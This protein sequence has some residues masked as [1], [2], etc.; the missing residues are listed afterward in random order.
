[1]REDSVVYR[2]Q[3]LERMNDSSSRRLDDSARE[4]FPEDYPH[5]HCG[6]LSSWR[7]IL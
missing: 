3:L 6:V 5:C 1:M 2:D 7:Q 4:V